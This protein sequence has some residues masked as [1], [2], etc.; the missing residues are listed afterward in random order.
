MNLNAKLTLYFTVSK[1]AIIAVFLLLLPYI[2]NWIS[3]TSINTYLRQQED[4]VFQTIQSNGLA[5][6]MPDGEPFGSY[7]MLKE[8]YISM[9]SI[10]QD[11][12]DVDQIADGL[13]LID[14]DTLDYRILSRTF[15][16]QDQRYLLEIGRTTATIKQYSIAI[17][18]IAL[19]VL[20]G[21]V[22]VTIVL[23]FFFSRVILRP[24]GSIIK[25]RLSGQQF[26]FKGGLE[27]IP[28]STSDFKLL[29]ESFIQ[30]MERI[31]QDFDR[32][33][34][35]TANASHELLTPISVLK[36]KIENLM[37]ADGLNE[38][39]AAKL[40]EMM[41][42]L[43][44]L[45]GIVKSM[46]LI[47][48]IDN[49]QFDKGEAVRIDHMIDEIAE[50]L[51]LQMDE[52]GIV[53]VS[54]I[55]RREPVPNLN[56]ELMFHLFSNLI[57]NAVRHNRQ[58]GQIEVYDSYEAGRY[59]V[60]IRDTGAGFP[61]AKYEEIFER[62]KMVHRHAGGGSGLGLSIVRSV[63]QFFSI[64]VRVESTEGEGSIFSVGF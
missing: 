42:T 63:A 34:E 25:T 22:V 18:R 10:S 3:Q 64:E 52:K 26:P 20:I 55:A 53:Y 41:R 50:E 28:T 27:P 36:S 19:Y 37:L 16:Y 58:G 8:E 15:S 56:K 30:L 5:Y 31:K 45:N 39:M 7:T 4:K 40:T 29:D 54:T 61:A 59:W 43:N 14:T 46:L 48:R 6:Y 51:I 38:N 12:A 35:F 11:V 32:E 1:L 17:R 49:A 24:L 21:L 57:R 2:F 44:R 33:K 9:E 47:A 23:D 60:H 13:R 62:F